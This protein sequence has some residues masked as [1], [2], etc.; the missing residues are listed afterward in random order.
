MLLRRINVQAVPGL[1]QR[2]PTKRVSFN[3][4][5]WTTV[6]IPRY[7]EARF[8]SPKI[9]DEVNPCAFKPATCSPP[10]ANAAMMNESIS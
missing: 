1:P 8:F 10:K 9:T 2:F 6:N 4:D 7:L 5:R 3:S